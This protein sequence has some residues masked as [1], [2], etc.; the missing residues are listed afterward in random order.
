MLIIIITVKIMF[1]SVLKCINYG[2]IL[3][4]AHYMWIKPQP[5]TNFVLDLVTFIILV[6]LFMIGTIFHL[7]VSTNTVISCDGMLQW[8]IL[9]SKPVSRV[10]MRACAHIERA[11]AR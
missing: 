10:N 9:P 7:L 5:V 1:L 3:A 11:H 8:G 4:F 2:F 6:I